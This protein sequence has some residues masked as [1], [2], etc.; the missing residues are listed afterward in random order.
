MV[1]IG[2]DGSPD[3]QAAIERAGKLFR[4]QPAVVLTVWEPFIEVMQRTGAGAWGGLEGV[5]IEA[6]DAASEA[7]AR[8][9]AEA[10]AER[11][12]GAGHLAR[13]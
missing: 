4:G 13:V 3:A 11:A 9:A 6:I 2:Y 8:K 12:R 7:A 5:E 1:L 10:G